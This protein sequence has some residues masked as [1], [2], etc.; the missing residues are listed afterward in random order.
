MHDL[1]I[2]AELVE[3]DEL[4]DALRARVA[5]R[6]IVLSLLD[7]VTGLADRYSTKLL[8]P[9][10]PRG[11]N[12]RSMGPVLVALGVKIL[13]VEDPES[14]ARYTNRAAIRKGDPGDD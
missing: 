9:K 14:T 6:G 10:A 1:R 3:Y 13:F 5:E 4:L 2:L 12:L 7:D 8:C 11:L